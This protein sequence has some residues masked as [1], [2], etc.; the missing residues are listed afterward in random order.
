MLT[1]VLDGTSCPGPGFVLQM[2]VLMRVLSWLAETWCKGNVVLLF[3]S[4]FSTDWSNVNL[5]WVVAM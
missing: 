5:Y 1:D 3:L 2:S 4:I